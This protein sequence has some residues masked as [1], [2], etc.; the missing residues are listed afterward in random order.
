M[1]FE[2]INLNWRN[3]ILKVQCFL[4]CNIK[5]TFISSV[6][7]YDWLTFSE[8]S[9][10][11]ESKFLIP[12][13]FFSVRSRD[14]RVC[15]NCSGKTTIWSSNKKVFLDEL[16]LSGRNGE[17]LCKNFQIVEIHKSLTKFVHSVL[18]MIIPQ[19]KTTNVKWTINN[20][21]TN[22]GVVANHVTIRYGF[23]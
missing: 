15:Y 7:V 18:V 3:I 6:K 11:S 9:K 17:S 13:C 16:F 22:V 23:D 19:T 21:K 5:A 10:L 4:C 20:S 12:E 8:Y 2:I 14:C 1:V